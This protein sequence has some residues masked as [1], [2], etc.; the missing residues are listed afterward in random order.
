M[1]EEEE[2]RRD[3]ERVRG[4]LAGHSH[5]A[6]IGRQLTNKTTAMVFNDPQ[7]TTEMF[8]LHPTNGTRDMG[9][10]TE[11]PWHAHQ[12]LFRSTFWLNH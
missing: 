5:A 11:M 12:R 9:K 10:V 8:G 6:P 1:G 2:R 7:T 3:D 4:C